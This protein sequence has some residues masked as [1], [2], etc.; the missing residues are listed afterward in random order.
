MKK[1]Y[2]ALITVCVF[3]ISNAQKVYFKQTFDKPTFDGS[4]NYI[5]AGD[6]YG[7]NE[8]ASS[9][10]LQI[11]TSSYYSSPTPDSSQFT[12]IGTSPKYI[13]TDSLV[14]DGNGGYAMDLEKVSGNGNACT[15]AKSL[16]SPDSTPTFLKISYDVTPSTFSAS[17]VSASLYITVG[18]VDDSIRSE[19]TAT[20]ETARLGITNSGG[21]TNIFKL[22]DPATPAVN[23]P[24]SFTTGSKYNITFVP[25][26]GADTTIY[27]TYEAPDGTLDSVRGG[28]WDA[29]ITDSSGVSYKELSGRSI[30]YPKVPMTGFR[31]LV[32]NSE[33]VSYVLDNILITDGAAPT[34]LP[35]SLAKFDAEKINTTTAAVNWSVANASN[36][37][38]FEVTKSNDGTNFKSIGT[39]AFAGTKAYTFNDNN[40]GEGTSYYRLVSIAKDGS[41]LYSSVASVT[42]KISGTSILSLAPNLVHNT[43]YLNISAAK[44]DNLTARVLDLTGRMVQQKTISVPQGNSQTIFDFSTLKAGS[45]FL[46]TIASDGSVK[47]IRFEKQ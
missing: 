20:T 6:Y 4:A 2:L 25:N 11:A 14:P 18:V 41:E 39:V 45:Y 13:G 37:K 42:N 38:E 7:P 8:P 44:A 5:S 47:T 10:Y 34:N 1:I 16:L 23:G 21:A 46:E 22:R 28:H 15:L 40:L 31:F 17:T 36:I 43:S 33:Q 24:D 19:N 29:W 12:Y 26:N 30:V 27:H 9:P 35:I 32:T 3:T